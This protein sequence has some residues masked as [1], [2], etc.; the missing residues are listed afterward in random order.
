MN[1]TILKYESEPKIYEI[2]SECAPHHDVVRGLTISE[3][4]QKNEKHRNILITL[5]DYFIM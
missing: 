3:H 5:G 4:F 1:S 2:R